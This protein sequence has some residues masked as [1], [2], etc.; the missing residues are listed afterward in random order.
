MTASAPSREKRIIRTSLLGIIANLGLAGAKAL[1]G[2][3]ANSIAIVLDAVNN[4][5]DALSSVI[6]I[7][8]AR[9][10]AKPADRKHPFGHGRIEYFASELIA[11]LV[12]YA[13]VTAL[14]ESVKK[15]IAPE[16]PDYTPVGLILIALAVGVKLLLGWHFKRV[17]KETRSDAL[18]NS[19]EDAT[20]D[21]VI[22]VSTLVAAAL[23]LIFGWKLEGWLGAVISIVIIRSGVTMLLDTL[24]QLLGRRADSEFSKALKKTICSVDG[25]L[26]AYDLFLT[27][28]G[29]DRSMGSVH[30]EVADDLTAREID[31][32]E[33]RVAEACYEKHNVI[34]T[35][36]GI[37][38]QNNHSDEAARIQEEVRRLVM[39]RDGVLQI[40]GFYVDEEQKQMR[41]DVVL[42]FALEDRQAAFEALVA[43]LRQRWP[44]WQ[45]QVVLESD[46]SD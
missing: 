2:L 20:L 42:D 32:L 8:G 46:I 7:L 9:Y 25:V 33:H 31:A 13:G 23:Y 37:Y 45:I 12:I 27:D 38:A 29:P 35:A 24:S 18:S 22:S 44:G 16:V 28:Y 30:V 36:V 11:M 5:T 14:I 39:A 10:S 6:T 40:H 17:G 26:G 41:F 19:G 4:L 15:I 1:I 3:L 34:M 21:A 43:D